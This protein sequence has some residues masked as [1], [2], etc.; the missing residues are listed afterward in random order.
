MIEITNRKDC[1]GC[2][3][4]ASICPKGCISMQADKE[5]FLYPIVDKSN[6]INCGLCKNACPIINKQVDSK[7]HPKAY[8]CF[9][10]N[11]DVRM[12]STSGGVFSVLSEHVLSRGGVVFG[13]GFNQEMEV[14]HQAIEKT[15]DLDILRMSKYVQS[16]I[17]DTFK[18][19]Q[20]FLKEGREVLF[21]GTP[22]QIEGL[23]AYLKKD[24]PNLLTQDLICHG[25]PSPAI[26]K[27][28]VNHRQAE[29]NLKINNI[30]F[31]NKSRGWHK[32]TFALHFEDGSCKTMSA[33]KD[34]Y[35]NMF[36]FN[37]NLRPSCHDCKFKKI[38]RASDITL[39]D[40]WGLKNINPP[41]EFCDNKG[42]SLVLIHS[43]KG[44]EIFEGLKDDLEVFEVDFS[45]ATKKNPMMKSSTWKHYRRAK[46]MRDFERLPFKKFLR[47][48]GKILI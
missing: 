18:Q 47:K 9:N 16:R 44:A 25:V 39:A 48:H 4:C 13:A 29:T 10:K 31:R 43:Q 33:V 2:H 23:M 7:K 42:V 40:F 41:K 27:E 14:A 46:V 5:G 45:K 28:Y 21:T 3:A 8:A 11:D 24:Y 35:M 1:S 19:A 22:C 17:G 20:K 37:K 30:E 12:K 36:F 32:K 26:L 34:G 38:G 6:C 15:E